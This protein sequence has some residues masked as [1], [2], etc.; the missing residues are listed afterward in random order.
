MLL[1][2]IK[3]QLPPIMHKIVNYFESP[4]EYV[5]YIETET[6]VILSVE[7]WYAFHFQNRSKLKTH[8]TLGLLEVSYKMLYTLG[9]VTHVDLRMR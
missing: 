4:V 9:N 1:L 8:F 7:I 6:F 5:V 3:L 2:P